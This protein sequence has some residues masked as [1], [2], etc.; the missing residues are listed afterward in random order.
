MINQLKKNT[1]LKIL[2]VIVKCGVFF[3]MLLNVNMRNKKKRTQHALKTHPALRKT[4]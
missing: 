2:L 4:K 3:F 1:N